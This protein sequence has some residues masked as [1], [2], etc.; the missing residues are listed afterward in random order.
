V[1]LDPHRRLQSRHRAGNGDVPKTSRVPW[2]VGAIGFVVMLVL[3]YQMS[4]SVISGTT[5]QMF[6]WQQQSPP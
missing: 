5:E 6:S 3:L 1:A 2:I 4:V